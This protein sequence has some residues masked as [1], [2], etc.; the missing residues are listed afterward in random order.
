MADFESRASA[1]MGSAPQQGGPSFLTVAPG[2]AGVSSP[3][4][5]PLMALSIL[6]LL[7]A[8]KQYE[9]TPASAF[10]YPFLNYYRII[11]IKQASHLTRAESLP[12]FE[13]GYKLILA[14]HDGTPIAPG[15]L[16]FN[17]DFY[18]GL[19]NTTLI[20]GYAHISN[21]SEQGAFRASVPLLWDHPG[22]GGNPLP[23]TTD[24]DGGA[25]QI[26]YLSFTRSGKGSVPGVGA[27]VL[28]DVGHPSGFYTPAMV[29]QVAAKDPFEQNW[30]AV[31][32]TRR[33]GQVEIAVQHDGQVRYFTK[34]TRK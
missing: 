15:S 10:K 6:D 3:A 21:A 25:M 32:S 8:P 19:A 26:G 34:P 11:P 12:Y 14:A 28:A 9:I 4:F 17:G 23:G 7:P 31:Y 13:Q 27:V 18:G 5:G 33:D 30:Y 2:I 1:N 20:P 29:N 24:P 22:G 16:N